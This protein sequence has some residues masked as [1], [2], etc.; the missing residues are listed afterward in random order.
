MDDIS[1]GETLPKTTRWMGFPSPQGH[2]ASSL[3]FPASFSQQ[4]ELCDPVP[5]FV[6]NFP[7]L[8]TEPLQPTSADRIGP[9][10]LVS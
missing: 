6:L 2:P 9:V 8:F 4:I 3:F 10:Y 1:P 5:S 7:H